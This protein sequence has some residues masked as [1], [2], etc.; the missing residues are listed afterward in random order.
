MKKTFTIRLYR[1][2]GKSIRRELRDKEGNVVRYEGIDPI[3]VEFESS[4]IVELPSY[5][6]GYGSPEESAWTEDNMKKHYESMNDM[7]PIKSDEE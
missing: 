4:Y 5:F 3:P 6:L 2:N 7:D 1:Y